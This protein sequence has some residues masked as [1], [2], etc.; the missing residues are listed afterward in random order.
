[1]RS[2]L[3]I[4]VLPS[5][6]CWAG[7][8][9]VTAWL[10]PDEAPAWLALAVPVTTVIVHVPLRLMGAPRWVSNPLA[11]TQE[12]WLPV[13]QI[14]RLG[15]DLA[16]TATL[17]LASSA[18]VLGLLG[19]REERLLAAAV[20]AVV[21]MVVGFGTLA[22]R[23]AV[24]R[25]DAQPTVRVAAIVADGA[26]AEG[27]ETNGLIPIQSEVYRDV[28]GTI[29]RYAPHVARAA[30]DGAHLVVLPEVAV[31]VDDGGAAWVAAAEAWARRHA[32]AI[33]VPFFDAAAPRNRLAIVDERGP[34][35][36]YEKQHPGRGLEPQR[37]ERT[38]VGPHVLHVG[39]RQLVVSAAICVDLDYADLIAPLRRNGGLLAAPSNDWFG[40]F[41]EL[42]HRT[43]VW[44]AVLSGVTTV[45]ATG[46]GIS[47]V[48]DGAGRLIARASSR[49]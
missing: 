33:V 17:A 46:H 21:L 2:L 14:G 30:A 3:V 32:V 41:E 13:V 37:V 11:C 6:L 39:G 49:E 40:G 35:A 45:R 4:T 18:V 29:R 27:S 22:H 47:A 15:G 25:V 5:S 26:T 16:V 24:R 31:S 10:V 48:F 36:R 23:A 44:T 8:F 20:A 42:H 12:P 34:V 9:A 7:G 1:M 28:Q 43:A 19:G 38:P